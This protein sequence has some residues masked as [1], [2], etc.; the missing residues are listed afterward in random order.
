MVKA[1]GDFAAEFKCLKKLIYSPPSP[2][3]CAQCQVETHPG[4]FG[5]IGVGGQP[6]LRGS[7]SFRHRRD[8]ARGT[9]GSQRVK[10]KVW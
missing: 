2:P 8:K 1:N 3:W 7:F 4:P 10:L 9:V 6:P 5:A